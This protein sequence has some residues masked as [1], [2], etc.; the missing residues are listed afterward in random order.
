[1]TFNA[2]TQVIPMPNDPAIPTYNFNFVKLADLPKHIEQTVD[3]IGVITSHSQL[4]SIKMTKKDG[5][6]DKRTLSL[7]DDTNTQ[8]HS[9][10]HTAWR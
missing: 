4:G 10:I 7:M 2:E 1:M 6:I 5:F 8:V 9:H 3:V